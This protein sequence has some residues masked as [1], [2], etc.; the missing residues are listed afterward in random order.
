MAIPPGRPAAPERLPLP[1]TDTHCHMDIARHDLD[2]AESFSP[3][4]A[5]AEA[6]AVGV[7]RVVQIGVDVSS[8]RWAVS[9]AGTFAE[10]VATVALHPNEAPVLAADGKLD[11]ALAEIDRL[12]GASDRVR[13]VGETGLDFFRTGKKDGPR[14]KLP[15]GRTSRSPGVWI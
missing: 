10:V 6:A 2:D 12:A 13:G 11:D 4:Q 1:V 14:R 7:S 5:L 8:S 15:F 9:A 3:Q